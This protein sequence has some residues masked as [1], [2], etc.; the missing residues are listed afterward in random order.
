MNPKIIILSHAL[1]LC[2]SANPIGIPKRE[3]W[4]SIS[5]AAVILTANQIATTNSLSILQLVTDDGRVITRRDGVEVMIA[6][7]KRQEAK[8]DMEEAKKK[9][10]EQKEQDK[11]R[12]T[13]SLV[14]LVAIESHAVLAPRN[15]VKHVTKKSQ[16]QIAED[17]RRIRREEELRIEQ[18]EARRKKEEHERKL[19]CFLSLPGRIAEL[20]EYVLDFKWRYNSALIKPD[21]E[22]AKR[23]KAELVEVKAKLRVLWSEQK[24]LTRINPTPRP[25]EY[26]YEDEGYHPV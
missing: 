25:K 12:A 17:E 15:A 18:E 14:T 5:N 2:V 7:D 3:H 13:P 6:N 19:E 8:D 20:E 11:L 21:Y 9:I 10:T 22:E 16:R 26:E 23:L 1:A 4:T 24:K